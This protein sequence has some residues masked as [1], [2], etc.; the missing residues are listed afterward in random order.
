[1]NLVHNCRF[2]KLSLCSSDGSIAPTYMLWVGEDLNA[3]IISLIPPLCKTS[4]ILR[5]SSF[6]E[7]YAWYTITSFPLAIARYKLRITTL[8]AP[9]SLLVKHFRI[10]K[11]LVY[12]YFSFLICGIHVSFLSNINPR[13]FVSVTTFNLFPFRYT[14]G[15][16]I[17]LLLC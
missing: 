13:N 9:H 4:S 11:R 7:E 8:S 2:N 12:F 10:F 16:L 1:M 17:C 15:F 6:A 14:S 3:P 5:D